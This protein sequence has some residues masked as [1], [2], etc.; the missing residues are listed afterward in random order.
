[1]P[2]LLYMGAR[3]FPYFTPTKFYA[4][5]E[6]SLEQPKDLV[7]FNGMGGFHADGS[8]YHILNSADK[9]TPAPWCN[10]LANPS[11]GTVISESG[12]SY[13]WM[14]NAHEYRL[15]PWNNDSISDLCGEAFYIRD[16]ESGRFWSPTLL[17]APGKSNYL[18]THGF[19]YSIFECIEDGIHSRL[20]VFVDISEA[21]KFS[22]LKI[23]NVSGRPRK[24]SSIETSASGDAV[25]SQKCPEMIDSFTSRFG[26]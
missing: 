3:D 26:R 11:F 21:I 13:T 17:P 1:M 2:I 24:L 8:S 20:T 22:V 25:P 7:F 14:D 23:K 6:S 9:P 18:T 4:S 10:V 15:T 16:E 5:Q 19:G 12:Q